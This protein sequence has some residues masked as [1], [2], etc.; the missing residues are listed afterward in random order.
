MAIP[1]FFR[2][3]KPRQFE[4]IP[5]YYDPEKEEREERVRRIKQELGMEVEEEKKTSS[6]SRGSFRQYKTRH[7][8]DK[9]A[10]SDSNRR[11][12]IIFAVL[13]FL[14]YLLFYR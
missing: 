4:H 3:S 11:L 2:L 13:A 1:R 7:R 14:A 12:L 10:S 5:I 6:I 8:T 9:K